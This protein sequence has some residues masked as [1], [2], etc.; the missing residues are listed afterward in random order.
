MKQARKPM[1]SVIMPAYN[2]ASYIAQSVQSVLD[3]TM[4]DWEL[5]IIDDC[6]TDDT[7]AVL[8]PFLTK[9]TNIHYYRMKKNSGPAIARTEAIQRANGK[10]IAFLD[11]DD[12]WLPEKLEKQLAFMQETGAIFSCTAYET[13]DEGGNRLHIAYIPPQKTDYLKCIRLSDPIGNLT[14]IYD[15]SVLGK[16]RIPLIGN[17]EDFALWLKI[18]KLTDYC[19]GMED[20]LAVYRTGKKDSFSRNKIKMAKY[21]WQLY[22][23]IEKMNFF[24]SMLAMLCWG[25]VKGTGIGL[26][27]IRMHTPIIG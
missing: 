2:C 12:I 22:H 9:H 13:M 14:V 21:H 27:K 3:Q 19:Y 10:Y 24:Q 6:S 20:I 15:Q 25:Y 18:L 5:E 4:T 7:Q 1:V 26:R 11:S 8:M 16:M 23:D 17:R